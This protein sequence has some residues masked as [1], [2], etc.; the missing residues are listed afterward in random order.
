MKGGGTFAEVEK[1]VTN[2]NSPNG[3]IKSNSK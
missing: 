1:N 3:S 2:K